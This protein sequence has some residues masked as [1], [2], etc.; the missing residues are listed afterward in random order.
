MMMCLAGWKWSESDVWLTDGGIVMYHVYRVIWLADWWWNC[1]VSHLQ[2]VICLTD[3]RYWNVSLKVEKQTETETVTMWDTPDSQKTACTSRSLLCV[4]QTLHTGRW[5]AVARV[6]WPSLSGPGWGGTPGVCG[7]HGNT[8]GTPDRCWGQGRG[9]AAQN[10]PGYV[11]VLT[12]VLWQTLNQM[13]CTE[14]SWVCTCPSH[15]CSADFKSDVLHRIVLGTYLS[16][17]PVTCIF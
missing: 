4:R 6:V 12:Q 2:R 13:C 7:C 5:A 8:A 17:S 11:P 16:F 3:G 15:S 9:T 14:L 10:C 1:D